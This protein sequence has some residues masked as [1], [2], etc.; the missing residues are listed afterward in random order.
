MSEASRC[1]RGAARLLSLA[2]EAVQAEAKVL[3]PLLERLLLCQLQGR[4]PLQLDAAELA[5]L[6][7]ASQ[8]P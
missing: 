4:E 8:P 1:Q 3:Q 5:A 7:T 6:P 2:P